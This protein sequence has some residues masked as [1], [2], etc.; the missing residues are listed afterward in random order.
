MVV[1]F[2]LFCV[3][4]TEAPVEAL[5]GISEGAAKLLASLGVKTVGDLADSKYCRWAEA[6]VNIA[7]YENTKTA[8]E[9]HVEAALKKLE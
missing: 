8:K 5:Q 1:T 2:V 9:R 7:E 6:I 3:S 4:T